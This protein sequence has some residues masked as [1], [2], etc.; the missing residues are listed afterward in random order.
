VLHGVPSSSPLSFAR[1]AVVRLM[2]VVSAGATLPI[3]PVVLSLISGIFVPV[4][5]LP[6]G[7]EGIA[8]V[9]PVYHLADGLQMALGRTGVGS[10]SGRDV[11]VLF[12]W[13]TLGAVFAA[14]RL[15]W[16]PHTATG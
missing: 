5:Q 4:D 6:G 12:V 8:R 11:A 10:L 15:R 13:G 3:I 9:F 7:L 14:R 1:V 16:E 2:A